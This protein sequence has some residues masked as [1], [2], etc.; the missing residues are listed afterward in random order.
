M[1]SWK[2]LGEVKMEKEEDR[3][4]EE[5]T[6][7]GST[8][9]YLGFGGHNWLTPTGHLLYLGESHLNGRNFSTMGVRF[10]YHVL[11]FPTAVLVTVGPDLAE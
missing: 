1:V 5:V 7:S 8:E 9:H 2:S 11:Q 6:Q 4:F 3:K 10:F